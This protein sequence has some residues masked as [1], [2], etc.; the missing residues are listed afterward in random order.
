[1]ATTRT[2]E[3]P[4]P[5]VKAPARPAGRIGQVIAQVRRGFTE[6]VGELRK[7]AWPD[8]DMTRNLTF[9]VVGISVSIGV[10]LGVADTLLT[11]LY[12]LLQRVGT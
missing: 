11:W 12:K 10:L 2:T 4:K 6:T 5:P 9:V 8:S 1:V 3:A 7:V